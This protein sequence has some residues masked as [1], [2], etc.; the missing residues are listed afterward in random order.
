MLRHLPRTCAVSVG[1]VIERTDRAQVDNIRRQLVVDAHFDVG[2]DQ[3]VLGTTDRAEL[4]H[5]RDFIPEPDAACAVNTARHIRGHERTDVFVFNN[6][7]AILVTGYVAPIPH[8]EILQFALA[9]LI[10]NRAIEG[11][12]DEQEFHRRFLRSNRFGRFCEDLHA[13][14]NGSRTGRHRL[15]RFFDLNEAHATV[16]GDA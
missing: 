14:G 6:A 8:C 4:W 16:R 7:L 15:W 3:H 13:L 10:A 11:M 1:L 5:S 12:V 2:A 9:A